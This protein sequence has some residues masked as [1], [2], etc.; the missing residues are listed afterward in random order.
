MIGSNPSHHRLLDGDYCVG[1]VFAA[2]T[3]N[4]VKQINVAA[5]HSY[6]LVFNDAPT[7]SVYKST[8]TPFGRGRL[9]W[10]VPRN[11]LDR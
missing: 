9:I 5:G 1:V 10:T 8:A 7:V 3:L 2:A 6:N 4:S 11:P